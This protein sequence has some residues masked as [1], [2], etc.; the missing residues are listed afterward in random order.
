MKFWKLTLKITKFH[1]RSLIFTF[2]STRK[3]HDVYGNSQSSRPEFQHDQ[4]AQ[5]VEI[6]FEEEIFFSRDIIEIF[7][8]KKI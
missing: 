2:K 7:M 1:N 5:S 8:L 6:L 3:R 4:T